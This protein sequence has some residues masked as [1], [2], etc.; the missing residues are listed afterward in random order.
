MQFQER[1]IGKIPIAECTPGRVYQIQSRNLT[2]GV[3]DGNEGFI[4]IREKFGHRYLF[5]EC[6]WDQGPPHGTVSGQKDL[7]IDLPADISPKESLGTVDEETRRAVFF[8][9]PVSQGGRGWVFCDTNEASEEIRPVGVPNH[10]LFE[11]LERV[12]KEHH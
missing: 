5:T 10:A 3:Y 1:S 7:G 8:D 9:R 2:F 11:F 4:G 12:E 6:H